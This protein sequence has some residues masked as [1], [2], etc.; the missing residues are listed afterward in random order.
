MYLLSEGVDGAGLGLTFRVVLIEPDVKR[1]YL[2]TLKEIFSKRD[3]FISDILSLSIS[4]KSLS[5]TDWF[6]PA[7]VDSNLFVIIF[8]SFYSEKH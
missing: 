8:I 5:A 2:A 6:N 7:F 1:I 3:A 4:L